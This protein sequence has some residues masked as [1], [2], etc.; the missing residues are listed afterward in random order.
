MELGEDAAREKVRKQIVWRG[1]VGGGARGV[2]SI[3]QGSTKK[4]EIIA[5]LKQMNGIVYNFDYLD[6]L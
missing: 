5:V 1:G 3:S 6:K 2:P 4:E